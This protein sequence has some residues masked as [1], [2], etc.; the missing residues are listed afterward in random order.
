MQ[1]HPDRR[2]GTR[3]TALRDVAALAEVYRLEIAIPAEHA[4]SGFDEV[5]LAHLTGPP[6]T[7]VRQPTAES[8]RSSPTWR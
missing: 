2:R 4:V 6:L 8:A 5:A 7:T 3:G 1:R